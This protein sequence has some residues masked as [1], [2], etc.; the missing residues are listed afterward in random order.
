[1]PLRELIIKHSQSQGWVPSRLLRL[2]L[3]VLLG[4]SVMQLHGT[5]W[6][7]DLWSSGDIYFEAGSN[8]QLQ[9]A[10]LAQPRVQKV[11]HT[12][13]SSDNTIEPEGPVGNSTDNWASGLVHYGNSMIFSLGIVLIEL[14]Y[15]KPWKV[16]QGPRTKHD[17]LVELAEELSE[18][19]GQDYQ[20]AVQRCIQ[21]LAQGRRKLEEEEFKK[22]VYEEIV[23]P[24]EEELK[25]FAKAVDVREVFEAAR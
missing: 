6:L 7:K 2:K 12:T 25:T 19:A 11:F 4:S 15:W 14:Y 23:T 21:G 3:A 24:L 10:L 5:G 22:K 18:R 16:L 20:A 17:A 1:M 8:M 9:E 13:R